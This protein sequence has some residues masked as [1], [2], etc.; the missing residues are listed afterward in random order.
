MLDYGFA[1]PFW[2]KAYMSIYQRQKIVQ[3]GGVCSSTPTF[4]S[5]QGACS[6]MGEIASEVTARCQFACLTAGRQ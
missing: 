5:G 6:E 4:Q 1:P 3:K 2:M